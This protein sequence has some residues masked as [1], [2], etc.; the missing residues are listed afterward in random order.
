MI[1]TVRRLV[2]G[3]FLAVAALSPARAGE[4]D[5]ARVLV[6]LR[7]PPAHYEANAAYGGGYGAGAGQAARRRVAARLAQAHGLTLVT[8]WP[9]PV[10]GMDC[11]VMKA[12]AGRT[13][14]EVV[15][16][17][18]REPDVAWSEP[19]HIY[20][21]QGAAPTPND[22]LY[23]LQ[24]A[25]RAWRLAD[26]HKVA[27]GR[28]VKVAVIDSRVDVRHP[29]LAGQIQL[30]RDFLPDRPGPP[31][32]HGTGVAG[33]IAAIGDNRQGV[34]GVAPGARLMALRACWQDTRTPDTLCDSLGLAQALSFAIEHG[35]QVINLSLSGPSDR[36]LGALIDAAIARGA[37]VVGAVDP[38]LAQGGFP[39]SHAGVVAVASDQGRTAPHGVY[40]APGDDIPTTQPGGKWSLVSG[41]SYAAAHVSGLFALLREKRARPGPALVVTSVSGA[42]DAC[43]SVMRRAPPCGGCG[44]ARQAGSVA[45]AR[46]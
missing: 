36:L 11:Y 16:S 19:M 33:V 12:P 46:P 32:R 17:L 9:M 2:L 4:T 35:A 10:L 15:A 7:M 18:T 26:L 40:L 29:D 8:G 20:R 42:V 6:M 3:L 14:D 41:S 39:A 25:A 30:S 45:I 21:A 27:T 23:R 28:D 24:P 37:T 31:E 1:A 13:A 5:P 22:P 44:C 34:V 43:A 38:H